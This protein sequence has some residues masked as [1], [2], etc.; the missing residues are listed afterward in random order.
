M[1]W[2]KTGISNFEEQLFLAFNITQ[3]TD[4]DCFVFSVIPISNSSQSQETG[5]LGAQ[6]STMSRK[7][8][9]SNPCGGCPLSSS[10]YRQYSIEGAAKL[11]LRQIACSDTMCF[12]GQGECRL[13]KRYLI[14]YGKDGSQWI[15]K[16]LHVPVV[17]ACVRLSSK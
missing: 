7:K 15:P 13:K 4:K 1:V 11:K 3:E 9:C 8:R 10:E 2:H 12:R 16:T 6:V 14:L 17:C 5:K